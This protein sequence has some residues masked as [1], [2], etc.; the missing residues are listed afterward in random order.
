MKSQVLI[1]AVLTVALLGCKKNIVSPT[2]PECLLWESEF[3]SFYSHQKTSYYYNNNNNKLVGRAEYEKLILPPILSIYTF[4]SIVYVSNTNVVVYRYTLTGNSLKYLF[5]KDTFPEHTQTP[6][7][8]TEF[9]LVN[10]RITAINYFVGATNAYE[11]RD[12]LVYEGDKLVKIHKFGTF[13]YPNWSTPNK[14]EKIGTLT[15]DGNN[16]KS[17]IYVDKD[18]IGDVI[19]GDTTLYHTYPNFKNP[20]TTAKYVPDLFIKSISEN[21]NHIIATSYYYQLKDGSYTGGSATYGPSV[22]T[23][24]GKGYAKELGFYKCD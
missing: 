15:Y 3:I 4:D 17:L 22:Y 24:N 8:K 21:L 1:L 6:S 11:G 23:N 2:D 7:K 12:S 13:Y 9:V 20:Y 5:N 16:L 19:G 10:N 18:R 14:G